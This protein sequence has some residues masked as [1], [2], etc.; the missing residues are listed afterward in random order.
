MFCHNDCVP[1]SLKSSVVHQFTSC[2]S[3]GVRYIGETNG[4]FN[5]RV[6]E[7]RFREKFTHLSAAKGCR[8]KCDISCFEILAHDST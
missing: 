5:A 3:C 6:N 2:A 7:N 8:D 1:D 4:H